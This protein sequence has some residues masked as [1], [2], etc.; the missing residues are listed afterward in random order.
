MNKSLYLIVVIAALFGSAMCRAQ[1]P[2]IIDGATKD[3]LQAASTSLVPA[4]NGITDYLTYLRPQG[5]C[6]PVGA[7]GPILTEVFFRNGVSF[8]IGSSIPGEVM[9]AGY[10]LQ[11]GGRA[12]FFT[13]SQERAFTVELG[14]SAVWYDAHVDRIYNMVD[15]TRVR[16]N[17]N[18]SIVTTPE[19]IPVNETFPLLPLIPSSMNVTSVHASLGHELYVLGCA[20]CSDPG[21]KLRLGYDVGGRWGSSKMIV[22]KQPF[23]G[24]GGNPNRDLFKHRTDVVGGVFLALHSDFE[25]PYKC[26]IF[27]A[28]VRSEFAYLWND[29][30]QSHNNTDVMS[31][32]LLFNLGCRF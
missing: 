20:D 12:L 14:I 25:I 27:F 1:T 23:E 3:P 22:V 30:L 4:P 21:A 17:A 32:N 10:M 18:G 15:V 6:G 16:R 9:A 31:I 2:P 19:G 26:A 13:P 29:L 11:G 7:H 28:G 24:D 5:C 8:P